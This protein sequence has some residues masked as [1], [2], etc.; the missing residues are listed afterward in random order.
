MTLNDLQDA[1][2]QWI[3]A[4]GGYWEKFQI[5]ARVTEE[6]GEVASALQRSEGPLPRKV[7]VDL[8]AEV[9]DLFTL[10]AFAN[11]ASLDLGAAVRKVMAKCDI[12]DSALWQR[13]QGKE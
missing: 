1:V 10:A 9:G 11:A 5:L 12:R 2:D 8:K 3:R 7:D 4:N 13:P 6:L